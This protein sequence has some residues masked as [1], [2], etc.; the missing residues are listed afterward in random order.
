[1]V[2]QRGELIMNKFV[3]LLAIVLASVLLAGNWAFAGEKEAATLASVE[4]FGTGVGIEEREAKLTGYQAKLVFANMKGEFLANVSVR[5]RRGTEERTIHSDG[6]WLF[7][8]GNPGR[9]E[10][11]ASVGEFSAKQ[12]IVLPTK[13]M[14]GYLIH[15]RMSRPLKKVPSKK[16]IPGV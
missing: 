11:F 13:G 5:V 15:L 6:P 3:N 8:K 16:A 2:F 4:Y 9:Y 10:I 14:R 1:M 7:L 12:S